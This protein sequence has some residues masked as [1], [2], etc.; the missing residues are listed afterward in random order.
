MFIPVRL[1]LLDHSSRW[2]SRLQQSSKGAV[3]DVV[4]V[5]DYPL[6]GDEVAIQNTGDQ[7][8]QGLDCLGDDGPADCRW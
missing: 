8:G 3:Q 6:S 4:A 5:R 2:L 7:L 1:C